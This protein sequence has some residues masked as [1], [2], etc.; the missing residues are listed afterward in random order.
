MSIWKVE[1]LVWNQ[2]SVDWRSP[3]CSSVDG[4]RS[5]SATPSASAMAVHAGNGRR[6][7]RA[8]S[9]TA[10]TPSAARK[11]A[12]RAMPTSHSSP[13]ART[14]G[15]RTPCGSTDAGRN[16]H[17]SEPSSGSVM[18]M[19]PMRTAQSPS[20][21][22]AAHAGATARRLR[23]RSAARSAGVAWRWATWAQASP[24]TSQV[25]GSSR[26]PG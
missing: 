9:A 1:S 5:I 17:G 13:A 20:R 6:R 24:S 7:F 26:K 25:R 10:P 3:S 23:S 2:G 12:A 19:R 4:S 11:A 15:A 21:A 22:L 18:A 14:R 16:G 8:T